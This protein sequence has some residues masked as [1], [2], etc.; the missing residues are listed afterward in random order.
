MAELKREPAPAAELP[1]AKPD[2]LRK[3]L[4]KLVPIFLLKERSII[5]H[6]G[7]GAGWT[8]ASLCLQDAIGMRAANQRLI[9]RSSRSLLFVCYGNIMRSPMAEALML[10]ALEET[11]CSEKIEVASAGLH[12]TAGREVHPWALEVAAAM[13]ISLADHRAKP[14]SKEM[15]EHADCVFAMDFQNKAELLTLYPEAASKIYL[16]SAYAAGR[17]RYREIAD[18][19][20]GDL[21]ATKSCYRE[22]QICVRNLITSTFSPREKLAEGAAVP[23]NNPSQ[24]SRKQ[25]G[26]R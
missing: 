26:T 8:Y 12:A 4:R 25:L 22:L 1:S 15:V 16:M 23:D 18:P 3:I 5:A 2:S 7:P 14:L 13:G 6:L 19:F 20:L 10:R 17:Q 21:E 11:P 24:A 9:P